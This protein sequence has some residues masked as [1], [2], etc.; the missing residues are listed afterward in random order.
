MIGKEALCVVGND[1]CVDLRQDRRNLLQDHV[2]VRFRDMFDCFLIDADDVLAV[3]DDA[4]FYGGR[5]I[6]QRDQ[7]MIRNT[8]VGQ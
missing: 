7:E 5:T 4:R 3:S 6:S 1:D 2:G 8:A